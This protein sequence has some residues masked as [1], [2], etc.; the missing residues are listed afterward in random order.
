MVEETFHEIVLNPTEFQYIHLE[1]MYP[2]SLACPCTSFSVSH[3][4][5]ISINPIYHQICSSDFVSLVWLAFLGDNEYLYFELFHNYRVNTRSQFQLLATLCQSVRQ[6]ID[7]AF[8]VFNETQFI[9]SQ[10][11]SQQMFHSKTISLIEDWKLITKN[12]FVH[13]IQLIQATNQGNQLMNDFFNFNLDIDSMS[14]QV[15]SIPLN[16]SNCSCALSEDCHTPMLKIKFIWSLTPKIIGTI[17]NFFTGCSPIKALLQS[18]LQ[19]FYNQTCIN[20]V[21][22]FD[23]LGSGINVSRLDETRNSPDETIESIVKVLMVDEWQSNFSF[24]LYY[25]TCAPS[26]CIFHYTSQR[27]VFILITTMI[28]IY[29]GLST[30]FQIL[31]LICLRLVVKIIE[32]LSGRAMMQF[33]RNIF[34]CR[35]EQQIA[36]RLH[37]ILV[38]TALFAIFLAYFFTPQSKTTLTIKPSLSTYQYL[39]KHYSDFLQCS[40]SQI[41]IPYHSF[42]KIEP[43]FHEV[44]SSVFVT[45]RWITYVYDQGNFFNSTDFRAT[46]ASQFQLLASFCQLSQE[47]LNNALW[48]LNT[49]DYID[50]Q[51]SPPNILN[52]KIRA[53]IRKFQVA[54]SSS[55]ANSLDL[56]RLTTEANMLMSVLFTNWKFND[57][58]VTGENGLLYTTPIS[59]QECNCGLSSRCTQPSKGMMTGCYPLEALLQSTFE[60]F[61]DQECI[62]FNGIFKALNSSLSISSK[63]A[64]NTTIELILNELMVENYSIN[65]SYER[66]YAQCTPWSCSYLYIQRHTAMDI[67]TSLISLYS[68]LVIIF[69]WIVTVI[70]RIFLSRIRTINQQIV[71][72]NS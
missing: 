21:A 13:T 49:T 42:L 28:G 19:C 52:E 17:P 18:T 62:D 34:M 65:I 68:G 35:N 51:L 60:C 57:A 46:S 47:T 33:I 8:R 24:T 39:V 1:R 26:S 38:V 43:Q 66:Y 37:F 7:N 69:Q 63:F 72:Q 45:D 40:C 58:N 36:R 31:A 32:N 6:M 2:N 56:I 67:L 54:T 29:G 23:D 11:V 4:T 64:A 71:V 12:K 20:M 70:I 50:A 22:T 41:G 30:G 61:Y 55:L 27:S 10:I 9:S 15:R 14:G 59:Y 16:Y 25:N 5:F 48:K 44:C 53:T 3:K